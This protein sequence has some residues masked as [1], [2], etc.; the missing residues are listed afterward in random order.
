MLQRPIQI[1]YKQQWSKPNLQTIEESILTNSERCINHNEQESHSWPNS[2]ETV[3]VEAK[4]VDV[5][6][7]LFAFFE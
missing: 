2:E 6:F 1:T 3:A 5:T 4:D 7:V